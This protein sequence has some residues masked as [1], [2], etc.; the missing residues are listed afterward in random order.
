MKEINQMLLNQNGFV[1]EKIKEYYG[2]GEIEE[3]NITIDRKT[4]EKRRARAD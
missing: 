3:K 1:Y 4:I 2:D